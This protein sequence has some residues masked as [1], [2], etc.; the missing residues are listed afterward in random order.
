MELNTSTQYEIYLNTLNYL[1]VY[2]DK[3]TKFYKS[4]R[5]ITD[6]IYVDS[7]TISKKLSENDGLC[8]VISRVNNFMYYIKK[9]NFQMKA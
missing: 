7:S 3:S 4:L 2:P 9:M 6:D 8:F 5:A 1:V